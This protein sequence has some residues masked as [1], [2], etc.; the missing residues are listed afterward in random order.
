[1]QGVILNVNHII[2]DEDQLQFQAWRKL[3]MYEYGIGLPGKLVQTFKNQDRE[4]VLT[5]VLDHFHQSAD[6]QERQDLLK[7]QDHFYG[8][9]LGQVDENKLLP[10]AEK[11]IISFYDHY[12]KVGVHDQDGHAAELIKQLGL[13]EYIDLVGPQQGTAGNPYTSLLQKLN[14]PA[15]GR[16]GI[17]TQPNDLRQSK[18][19]GLTTI[20]VGDVNQLAEADYRVSQVGDLRYQMLEKVWE[21]HNL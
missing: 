9:V 11:L 17:V 14:V 12:V 18:A 7:E 19:A 1:M 3:A 21:R 5:A 15:K 16:L 6:K 20:G 10:G 2:V 8:Q 13:D 4:Q